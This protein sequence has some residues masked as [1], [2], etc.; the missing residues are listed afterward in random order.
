LAALSK[1]AKKFGG[2]EQLKLQLE[3]LLVLGPH[4]HL[5]SLPLHFALLPHLVPHGPQECPARAVDSSLLEIPG[6]SSSSWSKI[7]SWSQAKPKEG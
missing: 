3:V 1:F 2:P 5:K 7:V 4:Q 6:K